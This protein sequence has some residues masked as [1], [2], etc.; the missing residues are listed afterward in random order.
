MT[1]AY[2]HGGPHVALSMFM[3][4][5]DLMRWE[6][7]GGRLA[8]HEIERQH[9]M[10]TLNPIPVI[11]LSHPPRRAAEAWRFAQG[12]RT[13]ADA[14]QVTGVVVVSNHWNR[15]GESVTVGLEV[16]DTRSAAAG[17]ALAERLAE[18]LKSAGLTPDLDGGW[19]GDTM[20]WRPIVE[21]LADSEVPLVHVSVPV[22]FGDDLMRLAA[23]AL[24]DLRREGILFVG[25][26]D[27]FGDALM[28]E[29][30]RSSH[31][32]YGTAEGVPV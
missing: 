23:I 27:V 13:Q 22:R 24:Q 31:G 19:L 9:L 4:T 14:L 10:N 29:E 3:R 17:R 26:S 1:Y 15:P 18:L 25:F 30:V 5:L 8:N 7:E 16:D 2:Q 12:I 20:A 21:A 6:T 28:T 11:A 32:R